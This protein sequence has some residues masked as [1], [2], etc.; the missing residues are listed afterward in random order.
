MRN[1]IHDFFISCSLT[2]PTFLAA[3]RRASEGA[4]AAAV[5]TRESRFVGGSGAAEE[6]ILAPLGL[7][8]SI[9]F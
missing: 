1:I 9:S 4:L 8:G 5:P 2:A 3:W 6:F 7:E